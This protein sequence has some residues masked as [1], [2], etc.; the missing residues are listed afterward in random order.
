MVDIVVEFPPARTQAAK[1]G[2][3]GHSNGRVGREVVCDTHV[4]GIM[5]RKSELVPDASKRNSTRDVPARVES[6]EEQGGERPVPQTFYPIR[7][8]VAIV[9]STSLYLLLQISILLRNSVLCL[10]VC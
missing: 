7:G 2:R 6:E 5:D 3:N 4:T 10:R 8:V 1:V 9:Q